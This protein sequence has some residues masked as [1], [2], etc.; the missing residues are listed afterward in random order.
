MVELTR[1]QWIAGAGAI[2]AGGMLINPARLA[3][4]SALPDSWLASIA[5]RELQKHGNAI[6]H[7]DRVA[8]AD[9]TLPSRDPRFFFVDLHRGTV[10]R[11][12][13]THGRGS[14]PE[15]VG[16]LKYFSNVNGS[17]ASSRGAYVTGDQYIGS[18]GLSLRLQGL[19]ADNNNAEPRAIVV[20]GAW[21]A[22]PKMIAEQGK[23]GRSEGCFAFPEAE[24]GLVLERLGNGRLI[25]ADRL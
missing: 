1:R 3:S 18:N 24:L 7:H 15:H 4:A 17:L 22:N 2:A 13:V 12:L 20:H 9:Y 6:R 5:K 10:D 16:Y 25:F 19:D 23:L 21:Y 8:I 11:H 14:D